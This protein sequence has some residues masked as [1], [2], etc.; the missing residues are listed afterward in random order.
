MY[1][2]MLLWY[3]CQN[4]TVC[5]Y[6]VHVYLHSCYVTIFANVCAHYIYV[7][8]YV[9]MYVRMYDSGS[10]KG[11]CGKMALLERFVIS[12]SE[13]FPERVSALLPGYR[14]LLTQPTLETVFPAIL[15][16]LLYPY[17]HTYIQICI[18]IHTYKYVY[19]YIHTYSVNNH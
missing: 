15:K 2:C 5:I 8:T 11:L 1:V 14:H 17:M 13:R 16:V 7:L 18:Y 9:C 10:S 6:A 19:T 3:L 12:A 4:S